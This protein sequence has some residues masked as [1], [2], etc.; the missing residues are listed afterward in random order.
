MRAGDDPALSIFTESIG[1]D[2]SSSAYPPGIN[3]PLF[4]AE[5][6]QVAF[7]HK[8]DWSGALSLFC[9]NQNTILI[10]WY[11]DDRPCFPLRGVNDEGHGA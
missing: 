6:S 2:R 3:N 11:R 7:L 1:P 8:P 4:T 10:F 5:K 9:Y